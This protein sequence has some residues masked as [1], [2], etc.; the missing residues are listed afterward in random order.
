MKYMESFLRKN[1]KYLTV[2]SL[3]KFYLDGKF[4]KNPEQYNIKILEESPTVHRN[5]TS[6]GFDELKGV[7]WKEKIKKINIAYDEIL[8]IAKQIE[9][10][11]IPQLF[12]KVSYPQIKTFKKAEIS[13]HFYD[14]RG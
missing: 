12:F 9:N 5:W 13:D 14:K 6:R 3:N 11:T 1:K 2:F 8:T 7:K 10:N 4:L